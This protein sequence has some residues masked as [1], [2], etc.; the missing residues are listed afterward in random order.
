MIQHHENGK[1]VIN[2]IEQELDSE[3]EGADVREGEYPII[4][5][6][7][8]IGEL[9]TSYVLNPEGELMIET[10]KDVIYANDRYHISVEN[11]EYHI[12]E[13]IQF[14]RKGFLVMDIL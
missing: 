12:N 10:P 5:I 11:D 3:I 1:I 6:S 14:N 2:G 7:E 8:R 9:R 13:M 4:Q